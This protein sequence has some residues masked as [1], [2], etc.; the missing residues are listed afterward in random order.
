MVEAMASGTPV[1]AFA[2]GSVGEVVD[3]GITGFIVSSADEMIG[4]TDQIKAIDRKKCR[5]KAF[6][7]FDKSIIVTLYI[8]LFYEKN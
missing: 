6:S 4:I 5:G 8:N 2:K 7:R 3:E 1:I